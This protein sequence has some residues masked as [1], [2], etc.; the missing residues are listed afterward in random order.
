[1]FGAHNS[2][3]G[4]LAPQHTRRTKLHG[5]EIVRHDAPHAPRLRGIIMRAKIATKRPFFCSQCVLFSAI[6][7]LVLQESGNGRAV[8]IGDIIN[9]CAVIQCPGKIAIWIHLFYDL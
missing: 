2:A 3:H 5:S 8:F 9:H 4:K 6:G 7:V 1:M